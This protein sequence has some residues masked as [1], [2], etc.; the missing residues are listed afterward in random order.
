M[1][2][3][4]EAEGLLAR[5]RLAPDD[6]G[7]R[8]IYADF[9]DEIGDYPRAEFIRVQLALAKLPATDDMLTTLA[10]CAA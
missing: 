4:G 2:M 7:P 8:L 1:T 10:A 6:D 9:L 3:R 5:I